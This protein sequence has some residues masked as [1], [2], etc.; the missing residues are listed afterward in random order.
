VQVGGATR[1]RRRTATSRSAKKKLAS[2]GAEP[3]PAPLRGAQRGPAHA[4]PRS[5]GDAKR[6][7]L[8]RPASY[9]RQVLC[10]V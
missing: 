7:A 2:R 1:R 8:A 9:R 3:V 4:G 6:L 10:T 5:L